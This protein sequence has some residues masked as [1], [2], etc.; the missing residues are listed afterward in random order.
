MADS[1][2][3]AALG[4][5]D[6]QRVDSILAACYER[7]GAEQ[8]GAV[9]AACDAHPDLA[10]A[11][12]RAHGCIADSWLGRVASRATPTRIADFRLIEKIGEGG[13]GTVYLAEQER[14]HRRV[15]LKLVRP[16]RL[17]SP[18][19]IERFRR[20]SEMA[21]RVAHPGLCSVYSV[22][23]E[24]GLPFLA[25]EFIRGKTLAQRIAATGTFD[26]A[27]ILEH[28]RIVEAAARALHA[29][30]AAG[31][32]HRDVKP[33]NLMVADDGRVVVLDFGLAR[34]T[35]A[36]PAG[37]TL[38]HE[39]VGTPAYTAPEQIVRQPLGLGPWT[40][41]YALGVTLFE[42]V[43]GR[44]PVVADSIHEL[45][46]LVSSGIHAS[47]R[48]LNRAVPRALDVVIAKCTDR[49][50]RRRYRTAL[51][52][53]DDLHRVQAGEPVT[54]RP[55]TPAL[56]LRRWVG[57]HPLAATTMALLALGLGVSL[58][59]L[60]RITAE[61]RR[62]RSIALASAADLAASSDNMLR[63][64]LARAACATLP[65]A[66]TMDALNRALQQPLVRWQSEPF[67]DAVDV[68]ALT[69][70]GRR[71]LAMDVTGLARVW[72]A[73]TH[74][75]VHERDLATAVPGVSRFWNAVISPDGNTIVASTDVTDV[76]VWQLDLDRVSKLPGHEEGALALAFAGDGR[77]I[78]TGDGVGTVRRFAL[79]G[80]ATEPQTIHRFDAVAQARGRPDVRGLRVLE[81]GTLLA[82][83]RHGETVRL[84]PDAAAPLRARYPSS[85]SDPEIATQD[86][87]LT[88]AVVL[89]Y[90]GG[91]AKLWQL[92]GAP[93]ATLRPAWTSNRCAALSPD[94]TIAATGDLDH[95][96]RLFD[97]PTGAPLGVQLGTQANALQIRFSP[98]G[99]SIAAWCS[100]LVVRIFD[101]LGFLHA[102]LAG[103]DQDSD[104]AFEFTADGTGLWT[105]GSRRVVRLWSLQGSDESAVLQLPP[106]GMTV[107]AR[108]D[109]EFLIQIGYGGVLRWDARS[110]APD[111]FTKLETIVD[112]IA[113]DAGGDR[114]AL[115][116]RDG[117]ARVLR[118]ADATELWKS[119]PI[120]AGR[121]AGAVFVDADHLAVATGQSAGD[122][123]TVRLFDLTRP[124][125]PPSFE[126]RLPRGD[127][128]VA[129]D[130]A[131]DGAALAAGCQDGSLRIWRVTLGAEPQLEL[132]AQ[133]A[134][135]DE[136]ITGV[137]FAPDG[138]TLASCSMLGRVRLH[139]RDGQ[140]LTE[141]I[142]HE[143]WVASAVFAND[144]TRLATASM[145]GTARV[146]DLSSG[147]T[148]HAFAVG[149]RTAVW[150]VQFTADDRAIVTASSDSC[151]RRWLL[152][153]GEL[154]RTSDAIEAH[155]AS[156]AE[157]ATYGAGSR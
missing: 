77:A 152:D 117:F 130:A 46:R 6:W 47:A 103:F 33:A 96:V 133:V 10:T 61:Q 13:M 59:L 69:P 5:V 155:P 39:V 63:V 111:V 37:L 80:A 112:S 85:G 78:F 118:E 40:D 93:I 102:T 29:A 131:R 15:A 106:F 44:L 87:S 156:T 50:P 18:S 90:W 113:V 120:E 97:A 151:A 100:D 25:M 72:T 31:L 141:L 43:T 67:R 12:R 4:D 22:G 76:L 42:A 101:R 91:T 66:E 23:E 28:L 17:G 139:G 8:D 16:D 7:P 157:L 88:T 55:L 73:A 86:A 84:D 64:R 54:A 98:D 9:A 32:V 95:Q 144:G 53:A 125:A 142:G 65:G 136:W 134:L 48:A 105:G 122:E 150:S 30:H 45:H 123:H 108:L 51:E 70:D 58:A 115:T 21:A 1:P 107:S 116:C 71:I 49:D 153:P 137:R 75:L 128:C 154:L 109:D 57:R 79:D 143:K 24:R 36:D 27:C 121:Y 132:A 129:I 62:T 146:W 74:E 114:I 148:T 126:L 82:W 110:P 26:R 89:T 52:L 127:G 68:I 34:D 20:E 124:D 138:R 149:R 38:S 147:Q 19:A 99:Q 119:P 94:G 35:A 145:D 41:V 81:D 2:R 14:P 56:R 92:D 3:E 11:L 60:D 135:G 83:S 104:R 140:V